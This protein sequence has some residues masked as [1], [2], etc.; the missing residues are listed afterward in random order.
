VSIVI[1]AS[2]VGGVFA[3][4]SPTSPPP[5]LTSQTTSVDIDALNISPGLSDGVFTLS[6]GTVN[7]PPAAV[8]VTLGFSFAPVKGFTH[9]N[10]A[11]LTVIYS[12]NGGGNLNDA[13][14]IE[15]NGHAPILVSVSPSVPTGTSGPLSGLE[16]V[17]TQMISVGSNTINIGVS[18]GRAN[19][20]VYAIFQVRLTV[21]YTFLA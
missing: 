19:T 8:N 21:E 7:A 16:P 13:L 18:R 14:S 2:L 3:T 9:A 10:S 1:F 5:S 20:S 11:L 17:P 15:V 12:F 4:T 6:P